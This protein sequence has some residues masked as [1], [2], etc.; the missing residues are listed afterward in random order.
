MNDDQNALSADPERDPVYLEAADW[1]GKLAS[2]NVSSE[3]TLAWQ[4]WMKADA[5][6]SAAFNRLD[7]ISRALRVMVPPPRPSRWALERDSYDGSIPLSEWRNRRRGLRHVLQTRGKLVAAAVLLVALAGTTWMV[8]A[9]ADRPVRRQVLATAIG[10]HHR[11]DLSDGSVVILGGRSRL[12]W[13]FT[14]GERSLEL[15]QGEALFTVAPDATRPFRV[16]AGSATIVALGT[17]FN[18]RRSGDQTVVA[19]TDG[20]VVV[21]PAP[22]LLPRAL[23]REIKPNFRPVRVDAGEQTTTGRAG[24]ESPR[25]LQDVGAV[26]SWQT[27]RLSFRLQPLRYVLEDVNRYAGKPIRAADEHIG[28]IVISGTVMEDNV[29]AWVESLERAFGLVAVEEADAIVLKAP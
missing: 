7:E 18:I 11:I 2:S 24:I 16:R 9:S 25:R 5:R 15:T 12:E 14:Q 19:V 28:S 13:A 23:L 27:G 10:E 4:R 6:H 21:E 26:T 8:F 1:G 22:Q 17:A 3:E 29:G 20:R